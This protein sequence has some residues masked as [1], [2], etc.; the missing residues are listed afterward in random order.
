M[1]RKSRQLI[2]EA[3]VEIS[4]DKRLV[5]SREAGRASEDTLRQRG[6]IRIRGERTSL[7]TR[8]GD[9][10]VEEDVAD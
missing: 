10:C 4:R 1:P 8:F 6:E 3:T 7:D 5:L 2:S 9:P